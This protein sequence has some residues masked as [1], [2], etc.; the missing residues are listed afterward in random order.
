MLGMLRAIAGKFAAN[1]PEA[2]AA[3]EADSTNNPSSNC[4]QQQGPPYHA[5]LRPLPTG[6]TAL[7]M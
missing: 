7:Q 2:P 3:K 6:N 5:S 4:C 1:E